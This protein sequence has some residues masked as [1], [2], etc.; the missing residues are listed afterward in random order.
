VTTFVLKVMS[1]IVAAHLCG[2]GNGSW[3]KGAGNFSGN[4]SPVEIHKILGPC[5]CS[6]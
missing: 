3:V 2:S 5:S 4:Y 1:K 6:E